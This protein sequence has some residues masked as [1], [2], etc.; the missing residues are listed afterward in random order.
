M[1]TPTVHKVDGAGYSAFALAR[2][3]KCHTIKRRD[4]LEAT[5]PTF[6]PATES[7]KP[8]LVWILLI[9]TASTAVATR[10][11]TRRGTHRETH[12]HLCNTYT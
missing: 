2:A 1:H 6:I 11:G 8:C 5:R 3:P 9:G 7:M 4:A 10:R 12:A